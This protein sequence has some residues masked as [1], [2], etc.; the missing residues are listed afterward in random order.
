M[1]LATFFFLSTVSPEGSVVSPSNIISRVG[2]TV[3]L[4]CTSMGGPN[5]TF[6]WQKN[7]T[8]I[9]NDS[10]LEL[11]TIDASFGGDYSCIVSNAAGS[12]SAY[13]TLYV[14]PYIITPIEKN[15][16][17]TVGGPGVNISCLADGF[18][19]PS[20]KWVDMVNVEVSSTSQLQL[21]PVSFGD[22]GLY[23]CIAS[24]DING[25]NF[26]AVDETTLTSK[27]ILLLVQY[28]YYNQFLHY[29]FP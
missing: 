12:D 14:E 1:Y 3:T 26:T 11:M 5:N 24:V 17:V 8:N 13:T 9:G 19:T 28:Y 16:L 2:D 21:N 4:A 23:Q 20:V 6:Q 25:T 22:E 29:S 10:I 27:I 18:P 7:G 15:T